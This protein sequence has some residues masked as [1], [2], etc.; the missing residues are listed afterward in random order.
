MDLERNTELSQAELLHRLAEMQANVE[1]YRG[2]VNALREQL[3]VNKAIAATNPTTS[4]RRLLKQMAIGA[5]GL[6]AIS[7]TSLTT[8]KSVQA[9]TDSEIAVT[10]EGGADGYGVR[11]SGGLAAIQLVPS[12]SANPASGTHGVGE[13][14]VDSASNMYVCVAGGVGTAATFRKIAGTVN[15]SGTSGST[16][17]TAYT[18]GTLHLLTAPD[19]FADTRAG[20]TLGGVAGPLTSN[21]DYV[22]TITGVPGR[23]GNVIPANATTIVGSIVVIQP[24]VAGFAKLAPNNPAINLATQGSSTV[25]FNAGF[26]TATSFNSA[27]FGGKVKFRPFIG[28][29]NHNLTIDVVGF[30]M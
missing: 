17:P 10:A 15:T 6:G 16:P 4:R 1:R 25:N 30:Y 11:A 23:D 29:G 26:N 18:A 8:N 13:I 24:T 9:V 12:T 22:F 5:A 19:R 7:L 2:E 28:T 20:G 14:F 21:N 27:L 3:G